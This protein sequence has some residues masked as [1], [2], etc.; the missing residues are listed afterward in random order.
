VGGDTTLADGHRPGASAAAP[1]VCWYVQ[2]AI[3]PPATLTAQTDAITTTIHARRLDIDAKCKW[4]SVSRPV[5]R[6]T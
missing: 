3:A 4:I 2:T 5:R 1:G 6:V